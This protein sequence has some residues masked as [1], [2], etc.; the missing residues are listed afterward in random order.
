MKSSKKY[1]I[2][3][4]GHLFVS[5]A[6][7][8]LVA[9]LPVQ[10]FAETINVAVTEFTGSNPETGRMVGQIIEGALASVP[11]V[12][13]VDRKHL[14]Q[15]LREQR[16]N[17]SGF[18]DMSSLSGGEIGSL[19]QVG[20][21]VGAT[22]LV[23]GSYS[24]DSQTFV[25]TINLVNITTGAIE[26]ST[27]ASSSSDEYFASVLSAS[28]R[29]AG[30]LAG[31]SLDPAELFG[32]LELIVNVEWDGGELLCDPRTDLKERIEQ[33]TGL[34]VMSRDITGQQIAGTITQIFKDD[35]AIKGTIKT[36]ASGMN[37][38]LLVN[39]QPV[40]GPSSV[41]WKKY[42]ARLYWA[43]YF[44]ALGG[45]VVHGVVETSDFGSGYG[46]AQA[47]SQA[48]SKTYD[49]FASTQLYKIV[50]DFGSSGSRIVTVKISG[51]I[52]RDH[53]SYSSLLKKELGIAAFEYDR[54]TGGI[55][56]F[57]FEYS[58]SI[59]DIRSAFQDAFRLAMIEMDS[60]SISFKKKI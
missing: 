30:K 52:R 35:L 27:V 6:F 31:K 48:V 34:P 54:F 40:K 51:V 45:A 42:K 7:V 55:S 56:T 21:L 20:Q 3:L 41:N 38:I 50:G 28:N 8:L 24:L 49:L 9:L 10:A 47:V 19:C 23:T 16:L 44:P 26:D 60:E 57:K 17:I 32:K 13:L 4:A 15:V 46:D 14:E 36:Y 2:S 43:A 29:F 39:F 11:G 1:V 58:G 12:T 5:A 22:H 25:L 59:E 37:P 18:V 33:A 53:L